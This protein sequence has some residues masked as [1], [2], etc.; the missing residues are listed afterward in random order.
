MPPSTLLK[1][2]FRPVHNI[3]QKSFHVSS[4]YFTNNPKSDAWG[5]KDPWEENKPVEDIDTKDA[6]FLLLQDGVT[7]ADRGRTC[8]IYKRARPAGQ[9]F[10]ND[11]E[12]YTFWRVEFINEGA[13]WN[14]PLMGWT[15][16]SDGYTNQHMDRFVFDTKDSAEKWCKRQGFKYLIQADQKSRKRAKSYSATFGLNGP[17][18][19]N[20]V[21]P[22]GKT[23][24]S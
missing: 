15:S 2:V 3:A 18:K 12:G 14:N 10:N 1:R 11:A 22:S 19:D 4:R 7:A 24:K 6:C 23:E 20:W 9:Q 16:T 8:R 13:R 21:P 17:P 5:V